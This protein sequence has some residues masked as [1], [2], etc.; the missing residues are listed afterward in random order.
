MSHPTEPIANFPTEAEAR[1]ALGRL[2]EEGLRAEV[3]PANDNLSRHAIVLPIHDGYH[4]LVAAEDAERARQVLALDAEQPLADGWEDAAE[5]AIDGW[6]CPNC[7]TEVSMNEA[8]C[9]ECGESRGEVR[10]D[11]GDED[12]D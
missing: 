9:P 4:L 11:D 7:D 5:Q 2:D 12:D 8:F 6:L 3:V 1:L 10:A